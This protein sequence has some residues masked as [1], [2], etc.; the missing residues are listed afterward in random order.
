MARA[1]RSG[2]FIPCLVTWD[3]ETGAFTR[4]EG[5]KGFA[6]WEEAE[7]AG[8]FLEHDQEGDVKP[9][10][11]AKRT[12]TCLRSRGARCAPASRANRSRAQLPD[13]SLP[14]TRDGDGIR[15]RDDA[16]MGTRSRMPL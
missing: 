5:S 2:L 14:R 6:T 10:T 8:R 1:L 15:A 3:R 16:Q 7:E 11:S 9:E 4:V 13:H 12:V